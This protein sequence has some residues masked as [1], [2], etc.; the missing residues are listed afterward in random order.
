[1]RCRLVGADARSAA[2]ERGLDTVVGERGTLVSGGERQR[3]ALA[4]AILRKPRLLVLDEA[5]GAIDVEGERHIL[6]GLRRL[7]PRP[8]IV[9][10]AHRSGKFGAVRTRVPLRSR[11]LRRRGDRRARGVSHAAIGLRHPLS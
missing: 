7:R 10:V 8:T 5:T 9:I 2:L 3:I 11:P 1:M 6:E 4:R